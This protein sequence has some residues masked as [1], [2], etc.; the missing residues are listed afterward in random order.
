MIYMYI[1]QHTLAMGYKKDHAVNK[2]CTYMVQT[3]KSVICVL[4]MHT[5]PSAAKMRELNV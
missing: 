5:I 2:N 1:C 3:L 4:A